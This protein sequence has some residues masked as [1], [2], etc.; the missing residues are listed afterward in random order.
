MKLTIKAFSLIEI[1]ISVIILTLWVFWIYKLIGNNMWLLWHNT[2]KWTMYT[3]NT[4]IKECLTSFWYNNLQS[5]NTG[6]TFSI[7]FWTDYTWCFLG[8]YDNNFSFTWI[9]LD[10]Q[11]YYLYATIENKTSTIISLSHNVF[12][13]DIWYLFTQKNSFDTKQ[14]IEILK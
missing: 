6:T 2:T 3:L 14:N 10:N 12:S 9:V 1:I 8:T 11:N 4:N 13:P 5:Y 7:Y